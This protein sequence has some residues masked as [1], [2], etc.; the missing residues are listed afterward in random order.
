[1]SWYR[2]GSRMAQ[3]RSPLIS[4]RWLSDANTTATMAT[5]CIFSNVQDDPPHRSRFTSTTT[6]MVGQPVL[7]GDPCW[8]DKQ[9]VQW[10][11]FAAVVLLPQRRWP[12]RLK[13]RSQLLR[14]HW[15]WKQQSDL[16]RCLFLSILFAKLGQKDKCV[17]FLGRMAWKKLRRKNMSDVNFDVIKLEMSNS[18]YPML[19][20]VR[21]LML[22]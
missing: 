20:V 4:T 14:S 11:W 1:M 21:Y 7:Q 18:H 3:Y 19:A 13:R 15:R 8:P 22:E 16:Y 2:K 6:V 17:R 9:A 10:S 5:V 12:A